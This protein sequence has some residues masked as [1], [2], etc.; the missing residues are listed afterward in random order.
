[1]VGMGEYSR[2]TIKGHGL[3]IGEDFDFYGMGEVPTEEATRVK[4][5]GKIGTMY[6]VIT[7]NGEIMTW[8]FG[9]TRR[10]WAAKVDTV[11]ERVADM[12]EDVAL[13]MAD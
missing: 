2:N 9:P 11:T 6:H 8:E 3:K 10:I 7:V 13:G 12:I 5:A 1:M 4:F